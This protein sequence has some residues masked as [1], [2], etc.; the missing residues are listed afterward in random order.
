MVGPRPLL[1]AVALDSR[2]VTH[3]QRAL[4]Q[5]RRWCRANG[6]ALPQALVDVVEL[7]GARLDEGPAPAIAG[8]KRPEVDQR[9]T[10]DDSGPVPLLTPG[11]AAIM[12]RI[13]PRTLRR[14]ARD[15]K[16]PVVTVGGRRRYHR[17]ELES[18]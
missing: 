2:A 16:V 14:H 4:D 5:H 1:L 3:L 11:E 17:K 8:H 12:L 18:L 10:G 9:E 13:S 15:G 7:L 6:M